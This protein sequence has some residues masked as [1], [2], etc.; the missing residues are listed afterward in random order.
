MLLSRAIERRRNGKPVKWRR[1]ERADQ[2]MVA[3]GALAERVIN[4]GCTPERW[5]AAMSLYE[6][7]M[8]KYAEIVACY[9]S[10]LWDAQP[11]GVEI[12][13]SLLER[14]YRLE[15]DAGIL[16]ELV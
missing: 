9:V 1:P 11:T 4:H 13:D 6:I 5:L 2:V 8:D 12:P 16:P 14:L 10:R 15:V 7:A 3:L